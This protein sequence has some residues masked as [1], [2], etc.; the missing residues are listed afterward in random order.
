VSAASVAAGLLLLA[1]APATAQPR[2]GDA[3]HLG[4]G[5]HV[6]VQVYNE[7]SLSGE[8]AISD[9]GDISLPLVGQTTAAGKTVA[10]LRDSV[11]AAY[12]NGYV[13]S[14]RVAVEVINYRPFYILGEVNKP[15]EYPYSA[16]LTILE[17]VATANGFTYRANSK[18]IFVKHE[19]E[20]AEHQQRLNPSTLVQ[21]GDTIRIKERF[22]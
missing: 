11:A 18:N 1:T 7:P 8:F 5:D 21:P 2:S 15:G 9:A 4:P 16:G 10:E 12:A 19:G 14:P 6:R 17:A 3:Y 22:F 13:N 20:E